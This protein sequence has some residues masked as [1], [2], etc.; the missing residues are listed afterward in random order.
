M[1]TE[2]AEREDIVG[3]Y[4]VVLIATSIL[5]ACAFVGQKDAT[6]QQQFYEA[7]KYS[8]LMIGTAATTITALDIELRPEVKS[9][10]RM[11]VRSLRETR[12]EVRAWVSSCADGCAN[13]ERIR[14]GIDS[15]LALANLI[16][17]LVAEANTDG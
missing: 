8:T 2:T 1:R 3:A 15:M 5:I 13:E 17:N 16:S 6:I 9:G 12:G 4:F 14:L 10:L 7:D 11:A